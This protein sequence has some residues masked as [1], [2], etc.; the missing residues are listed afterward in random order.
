MDTKIEPGDFVRLK[1]RVKPE[2]A[3]VSPILLQN[4]YGWVE[5]SDNE[6]DEAYCEWDG[7]THGIVAATYDNG[8]V[9][10]V[11]CVDGESETMEF[12]HGYI[13]VRSQFHVSD[14]E[15]VKKGND[16]PDI[17]PVL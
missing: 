14:V 13:P 8:N 11:Y 9:V 16:F 2:K 12:G 3:M 6:S 15:L 1:E 7:F 4:V 5:T 10:F 17:L